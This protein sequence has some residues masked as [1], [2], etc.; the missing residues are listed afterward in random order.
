MISPELSRQL[1]M[2]RLLV[3]QSKRLM[4]ASAERRLGDHENEHLRERV[5]R[6]RTDT[7][8]A[9]H[10]YRSTM[11]QCGSPEH[12]DYW[13]IAYGRLVE[14]GMALAFRLRKSIVEL[15]PGDRYE[16]S[17]DIEMVE[18]MV[19]S[20]TDSMRTAIAASVA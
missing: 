1:V 2:G 14:K 20:W 13:P 4:L 15:P 7:H 3:L 19:D 6:L 12:R 18:A 11:I 17:T 5:D 9:Q 16:A 8:A 10:E